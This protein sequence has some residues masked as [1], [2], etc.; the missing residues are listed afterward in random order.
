MP[1]TP[2]VLE[3]QEVATNDDDAAFAAGFD[4]TDLP[5][6][7]PAQTE[8]TDTPAQPEESAPK[9]KQITEDEFAQLQAAASQVESLKATVEKQFGTAFGKMGGIERVLSQIQ[10]ATPAGQVPQASEADFAELNADYGDVTAPMIAGLNRVLSKMRG[11]AAND[12]ALNERIEKARQE[13]IEEA[14]RQREADCVE[15]V[16]EEHEDWQQVLADPKWKEYLQT[17]PEERQQRVKSSWNPVVISRAISGFKEYTK[18]APKADP[19]PEQKSSRQAVLEAS[20]NPRGT[21]VS[22]GSSAIDEFMAG[23]NSPS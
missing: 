23:F 10:S 4:G 13:A 9:L 2:E 3:N 14:Q 16:S 19:K 11:T 6:E 15:A 17:L 8:N 22:K 18:P 5:T 7:T 20:V 12:D 21:P 1:D